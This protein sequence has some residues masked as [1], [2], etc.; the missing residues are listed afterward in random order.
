MSWGR[1]QTTRSHSEEAPPEEET[2]ENP[3]GVKNS[4]TKA[5]VIQ[6]GIK[7]SGLYHY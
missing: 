5:K 3:V 2:K 7:I 6:T 1:H 4:H